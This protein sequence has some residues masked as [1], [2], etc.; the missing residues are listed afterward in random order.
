MDIQQQI[1]Q[2]TAR[3]A[4]VEVE[5]ADCE[6]SANSHE[7]QAR[8]YRKRREELKQERASLVTQLGH[9]NTVSATLKAQQAA[10]AAKTE[11]ETARAES[12]KLHAEAAE[13]LKSLQAQKEELD[14]RM[15]DSGT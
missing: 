8:D 13:L 2:A 15:K 3:L 11:A 14:A 7:A 1:T 6:K 12:V 5:I 4:A 10:E 9:N